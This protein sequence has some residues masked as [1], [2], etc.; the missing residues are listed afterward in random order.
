MR[1]KLAFVG[2][3]ALVVGAAL[4]GGCSDASVQRA[5]VI[6]NPSPN[7]GT[8]YER[9]DDVINASTHAFD[10]NW[11]SFR[12]DLGRAFLTDRPSRLNWEPMR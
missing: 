2:V 4:I 12:S 7:I 3:S 9:E 8:M 6:F 10:T 11:R 5:D 1:R